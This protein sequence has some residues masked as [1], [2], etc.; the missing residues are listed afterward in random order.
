MN[1]KG[2]NMKFF[3]ADF[4]EMSLTKKICL[5]GIL[6]ALI[7]IFNKVLAI[8]YIIPFARISFGSIALII[9]ASIVLGPFY[10]M[11]IAGIADVLG[12]FLFDM[13]SYG[14]FPQITLT[15]VLMGFVP[16]FIY[17]FV[18]TIKN[19]K[20]SMIIEYSVFAVILA[21]VAIFFIT[22]N[23]IDLGYKVYDLTLFD[24]IFYPSLT[25]LLFIVII[26]TNAFMNKKL[27]SDDLP[28]NIYQISFI[29][30]IVELFINLLFGGLMKSWAFGWNLLIPIYLTQGSILFFN[31]P[32]N[33]YLIF[34][35]MK[36]TKRL[37]R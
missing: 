7:V 36:T 23:K 6:M 13:S 1:L 17:K 32:Y 29:V 9:F 14:W 27:K 10:G 15:Y 30:F 5:S 19:P 21:L 24:R 37:S 8:N 11:I 28:I 35:I 12:Y 20:I 33:S 26:I 25:L 31:I 2:E 34:I 22:Q 3:K 16:F 4:I 18:K